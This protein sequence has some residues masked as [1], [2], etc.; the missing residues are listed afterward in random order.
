MN[1]SLPGQ[2]T[3]ITPA[4]LPAASGHPPKSC[5]GL[6]ICE[7]CGSVR[8]FFTWFRGLWLR[9]SM[10]VPGEIVI[11]TR[12]KAVLEIYPGFLVQKHVQQEKT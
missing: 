3:L 1:C 7:I 9:A 8:L 10:F 6:R 11:N 12:L 5:E 2:A 4:P